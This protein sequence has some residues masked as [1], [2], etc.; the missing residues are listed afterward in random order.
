M[1]NEMTDVRAKKTPNRA[2]IQNGHP[3]YCLSMIQPKIAGDIK[4]AANSISVVLLVFR[5]V[6]DF[7]VLPVIK[8][9]FTT[10]AWTVK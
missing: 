3:K 9:H 5:L 8:L 10:R 4:L 1:K 7:E 2:T 6:T